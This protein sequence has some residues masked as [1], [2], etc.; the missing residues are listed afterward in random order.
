MK[1]IT[2]NAAGL[3]AI[4]EFLETKHK[5]KH[6]DEIMLHDWA[7]EAEINWDEVNPPSIEIQP[8]DSVSQ[9]PETLTLTSDQYVISESFEYVVSWKNGNELGTYSGANEAQAIEKAVRDAGYLDLDAAQEFIFKDGEMLL[10]AT[11]LEE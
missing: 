7:C 8:A 1:Y 4:R 2:V 10:T 5:R 9:R 11:R 6:F 3:N